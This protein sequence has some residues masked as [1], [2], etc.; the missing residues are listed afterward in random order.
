MFTQWKALMQQWNFADNTD[1]YQELEKLYQQKHRHYHTL[2][3]I[4][5]CLQRLALVQDE[6]EHKKEIELA[7]WFHDAIYQPYQRDN[8]KLSAAMAVKFL[9]KNSAEVD[10]FNRVEKLIMITEHKAQPIT[11][12][13]K[14]M[15]DVDLA[16]LA[17]DDI[18]FKNFEENVRNEYYLVPGFLYRSKRKE[19]LTALLKR[20]TIY[21]TQYALK[22]WESKARKN[23]AAYC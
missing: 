1:T 7:L 10:A 2:E 17:A 22:E 5:V 21:Y 6:A 4:Q 13:E 14:I 12:D 15:T 3:H 19:L 16:V 23:L 18:E 8:E 9:Q 11:Q 20:P